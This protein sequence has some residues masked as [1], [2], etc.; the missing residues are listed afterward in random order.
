VSGDGHGTD[1]MHFGWNPDGKICLGA[2]PVHLRFT[3]AEAEELHAGLSALLFAGSRTGCG[4]TA[5]ESAVPRSAKDDPFGFRTDTGPVPA[6]PGP[7]D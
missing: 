5:G 7:G 2:G 6:G 4:C 1:R 3:R